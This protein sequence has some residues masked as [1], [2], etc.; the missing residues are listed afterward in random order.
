MGAE[1]A[2]S[3]LLAWTKDVNT[4]D[5]EGMTPLHLAV[6]KA[7]ETGNLYTVK[8]LMIRGAERHLRVLQLL[9]WVE[10]VGE[11]AG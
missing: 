2:A 5:R 4:P 6:E 7:L 11:R 10:Q 8:E 9:S 1:Q 3:Y